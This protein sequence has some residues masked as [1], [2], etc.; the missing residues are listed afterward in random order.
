MERPIKSGDGPRRRLKCG[1]GLPKRL[2]RV[3]TLPIKRCEAV[4]TRP[5]YGVLDKAKRGTTL[6]GKVCE[7]A[8]KK[9]RPGVSDKVKRIYRIPT[10]RT[11]REE[12]KVLAW[13]FTKQ[14]GKNCSK[15]EKRVRIHTCARMSHV[16]ILGVSQ[17]MGPDYQ[18][19]RPGYHPSG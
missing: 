15:Q 2:K 11:A 7:V 3:M 14:S 5:R 19:I 12:P 17:C 16:A 8:Y 9:L 6:P 13:T 18:K 10:K 1:P 4:F